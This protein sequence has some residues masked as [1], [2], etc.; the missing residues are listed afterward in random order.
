LIKNINNKINIIE[1]FISKDTCEFLINVLKKHT[2]EDPKR[3]GF[4]IALNLDH[5]A[6]LSILDKSE[7]FERKDDEFNLAA[8]KIE[9]IINNITK[10]VSKFY[11]IEYILKTFCYTKMDVGTKN[12]IH[13][14]NKYIDFDG[15]I[16]D[17]TS[18]IE[19][20][21]VLLYLNDDYEGGNLEFPNQNISLKPKTGTLVF[22]EG[23]EDTIHG[24]SEVLSGER[25]NLISFLWPIKYA[26]TQPA[27][28][29]GVE[30]QSFPVN[31]KNAIIEA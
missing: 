4:H 23:N 29:H 28:I 25:I 21:S 31:Y 27:I 12:R 10:E 30:T 26:G 9:E 5:F 13:A 17:R 7:L 18:E 22:F 19:D 16:K 11:N 3:K 8:K 2:V 14:D 15:N 20:R 1:N 24:V 6:A